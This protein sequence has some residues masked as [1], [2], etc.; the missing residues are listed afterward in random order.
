MPFLSAFQLN[1]GDQFNSGTEPG[2]KAS[3]LQSYFG[4]NVYRVHLSVVGNQNISFSGDR[5]Q[6]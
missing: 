3:T 2:I 1:S 6:V 4:I 5:P